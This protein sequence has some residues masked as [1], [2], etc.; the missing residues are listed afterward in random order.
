MNLPLGHKSSVNYTIYRNDASHLYWPTYHHVQTEPL[1]SGYEGFFLPINSCI[2]QLTSHH[3]T[4]LISWP[5]QCG[6]LFHFP[7]RLHFVAPSAGT[8]VDLP[9][10]ASSLC[11]QFNKQHKT[12]LSQKHTIS[13]R[14]KAK[15]ELW[16][17][18]LWEGLVGKVQCHTFVISGTR[19][20]HPAAKGCQ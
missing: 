8:T 7:V 20:F 15:Q 6:A 5:R 10:G 17:T 12:K 13:V 14:C 1:P 11:V 18:G 4:A 2:M 16:T 9:V 19:C 3:H